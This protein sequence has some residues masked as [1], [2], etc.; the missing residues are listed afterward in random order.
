MEGGAGMESGGGVGM[1]I[2]G[3]GAGGNRPRET[4]VVQRNPTTSFRLTSHQSHPRRDF[5]ML[6]TIRVSAQT[7]SRKRLPC[8]QA[9]SMLPAQEAVQAFR[10][11]RAAE[12]MAVPPLCL[13]IVAFRAYAAIRRSLRETGDLL[14]KSNR[15]TG[16]KS[17]P[18]FSPQ[19]A[20]ST[21]PGS[22]PG[23]AARC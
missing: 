23:A 4:G 8:Q 2:G 6:G 22:P 5:G 13:A 7:I 3:K 1:A 14:W 11:A 15:Q 20:G 10:L 16:S 18:G 21:R 19:T 17:R 12:L 9:A